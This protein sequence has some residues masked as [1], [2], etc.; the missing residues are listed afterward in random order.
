[1]HCERLFL[2]ISPTRIW[3]LKFIL[4]GYDGLATLSTVNR[5]KGIVV[6]YYHHKAEKSLLGLLTSL[7]TA[8]RLPC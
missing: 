6:L 4:E 7:A 1:M 2:R 5:D 3:Y 8:L